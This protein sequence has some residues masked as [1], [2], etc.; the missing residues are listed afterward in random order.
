M[1]DDGPFTPAN[2]L[3]IER[4]RSG[5]GNV[6]GYCVELSTYSLITALLSGLHGIRREVPANSGP[7]PLTF[8]WVPAS[9]LHM[10]LPVLVKQF[11]VKKAQSVSNSII[12]CI[13]TLKLICP[14][15]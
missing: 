10:A 2:I 7:H 3:W 5:P 4:V 1:I 15:V 9:I 8:V 14:L 11:E 12:S 13:V 6:P